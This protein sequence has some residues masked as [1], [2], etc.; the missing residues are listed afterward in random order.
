MA[1]PEKEGLSHESLG[2]KDLDV[3]VTGTVQELWQLYLVGLTEGSL[4]LF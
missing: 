1:I 3:N 2:I 4:F